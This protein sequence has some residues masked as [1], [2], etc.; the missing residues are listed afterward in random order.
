MRIEIQG[1]DMKVGQELRDT[2]NK[3]LN[4][5]HRYFKDDTLC[6]VKCSTDGPD[7]KRV[8]ITLFVDGRIY[9]AERSE[10]DIFT[11]LDMAVDVLQGQIR[12]HKTIMANRNG[13]YSSIKDFVENELLDDSD[14]AEEPAVP[15]FRYKEFEIQPM[16]D[17][18]A[19]L[20]MDLLGHD[21]FIYLSPD[22]GKVNVI[23]K[24]KG[25]SYGVIEPIY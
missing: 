8:E 22:S 9:R 16:S 4:K 19:A 2:I 5:F 6:Q 23:Y 18:E 24:R 21:F 11:A 17:E 3:K 25:D 12:K 20:Q 10:T 7:L 15:E 14:E 1:V 13:D